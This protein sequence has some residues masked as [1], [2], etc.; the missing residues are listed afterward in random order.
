ME[1]IQSIDEVWKPIPGTSQELAIDTRCHH[2][3]YT[4]ARGPGKALPVNTPVPTTEGWKNHGDLTTSDCVY[5]PS[6]S[7]V[8][9]LAVFDR[10]NRDCYRLTFDDNS[11]ILAD[12]EHLWK[13]HT[14]GTRNRNRIATTNELS[15]RIKKGQ[16]VLIP[17]TDAIEFK[18]QE[19]PID[20]YLL[21]LL[22]GDGSQT[23]NR[24]MYCTVDDELAEYVLGKGFKEWSCDT[25]N[26]VRNFGAS[27]MQDV[28][29]ELNLDERRSYEKVIPRIYCESSK[30]DRL[31]LLQGL[32]DTD[33]SVCKQGYIE[34]CSVSASLAQGVAYLVRS[35]GG[36]ATVKESESWLCDKQYRNRYRV[37]IQPANKFIP[38]RLERKYKRIA[39]YMHK[40]LSRAIVSIEYVGKLDCNCISVDNENGLYVAGYNFVVTHNTDC[41]LMRFRRRVGQG[42]GAFWRGIIFDREYKNLED[43]IVKSKRWFNLFDD[44]AS[45]LQSASSLKWVW[46]SGEELLFRVAEKESDYWKYHGHEY[47]FIGWNELTKYPTCDL[48]DMMMSTNRS[49]FR[50][51]DYPKIIDG[52]YYKETGQVR[53]VDESYPSATEYILPAIPLEVFSTCNP[54]GPGHSW[55]KRRFIDPAPYGHVVRKDIEVTNPAT[56]QQVIVS[57]TQVAIFGSYVENIYLSPEYV[58]ELESE[59]DEN[60]RK[61]WLLGSWD[62]VAGGALDDVW[63]KRFHVL[64]RFVVPSSWRV[65]RSFDWG[66]THPFSVGWW[67]EANGEEAIIIQGDKVFSFCPVPGSLIQIFEWYGTK[68]PGTNKGLKMGSASVAK[69][70]VD[71]E[72]SL[73]A[74]GWIKE[75]PL[76]GPADNQIHNVTD[77]ESDT[78][79]HKM[80]SNGIKWIESDKSP[81]SRINGLELFRERLR[82]AVSGEGPA[83][84][85]M[86]NCRVSVTMLPTLPRNPDKPD[87]VDTDAEDHFWDMIRYRVLKSTNRSAKK[88]KVTLPC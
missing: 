88:V 24:S 33:G 19:L 11:T 36:K 7:F 9:V 71:R 25:R 23:N 53:F 51:Q 47:P 12:G 69:G 52:D 82:S 30:E 57:K 50:P 8:R 61:A 67:A 59:K 46:P 63:D 40:V 65:D 5:S 32:L 28:L 2:T 58:A 6:G 22:L 16:R 80:A 75:Q 41:Q 70:I 48:Y 20:P 73:L 39:H 15:I 49:S 3:L 68:E 56:K 77:D 79:A 42:Y 35:L 21:G 55:V 13:F 45:F 62:I 72:I 83:I 74:N 27:G 29:R 87:D 76:P 37:Y 81:G 34:F 86:E 31:S 64:P 4:G 14:V 60:R 66:S 78:I 54:W 44:G 10:P 85:F 18:K 17:T 26:K 1:L 38:F 84:Y 43:L